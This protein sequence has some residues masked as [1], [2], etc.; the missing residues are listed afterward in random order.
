MCMAKA[1]DCVIAIGGLL[2][3]A[4]ATLQPG[5]APPHGGQP[6]AP[7]PVP[8]AGAPS[9]DGAGVAPSPKQSAKLVYARLSTTMGDIILE[10]NETA[11]P[12]TVAN[13]L[14]YVERHAYDGTIFHRV[15]GGFVIQGGGYTP[16]LQERAKVE[17][18][19]EN[20]DPKIKNEWTN[21]LKN[22]RGSIAMARDADPDTATREFY[23]NVADNPKLD[24]ARE[25]TG[26]AG[27]CV[28]GRVVV[29]LDVVDK[30]RAVKTGPRPDV[31]VDD[32]S[33][34]N[35]PDRKSVV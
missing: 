29:G 25:Q 1:A 12:V 8:D 33:M 17:G 15:I 34:E 30:I 23:I 31:K 22:V 27:Y 35:V 9:K 16:D 14:G 2:G 13:F 21:G 18:G 11:A 10:L 26:K 24:T 28:F 32:G 3:S 19:G 20:K 6:T 7:A 4:S 5:Q